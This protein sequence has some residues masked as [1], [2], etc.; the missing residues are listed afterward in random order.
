MIATDCCLALCL[1]TVGHAGRGLWR[2]PLPRLI[3][4]A[5]AWR[6][7]IGG[8]AACAKGGGRRHGRAPRL[9]GHHLAGAPSRGHRWL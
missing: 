1:F 6:P 8:A 4:H 5:F 3:H 9:A 2:H 7:T